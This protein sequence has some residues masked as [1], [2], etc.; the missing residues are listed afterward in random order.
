MT[1]KRFLSVFVALVM[2]LGLMPTA[3]IANAADTTNTTSKTIQLG[4][5]GLKSPTATT[6]EKGTYKEPNSYVYF[7]VNSENNSTPIKWRVLDADKANDGETNGMFLLSEYYLSLTRFDPT[8]P[9]DNTYQESVAKAWC[10]SFSGDQDNFSSLEYNNMLGI[11]KVDEP[12]TLYS[13]TWGA[14]T[15]TQYDKLFLLSVQELADYVGNYNE[16]PGLIAT[17]TAGF[18]QT[19]WLRSPYVYGNWKQ[20]AASVSYTGE[21]DNKHVEDNAGARPALNLNLDNVL[22]TSAAEDGKSASGMDSDLTAVNDYTGNEWKLT[23]KDTT[24]NFSITEN[25][26]TVETG[27]TITLNYSGASVGTNEYISA[28]IEDSNSNVSYYGR[29]LKPDANGGSMDITIPSGLVGGTCTLHLFSEQYNGGYKTDYASSFD[30]VSLTVVHNHA[31]SNEWSSDDTAHWHDCTADGCPITDNSEK[32]GY[33]IH[34]GGT[35]TCTAKAICADCG[36]EYGNLASHKLTH[37][38]AKAA[39]ATKTGNIEYWHCSDCDKY[40]KDKDAQ[41]EITNGINGTKISKLNANDNAESSH[42]GDNSNFALWIALLFISCTTV[43]GTTVVSRKKKY[44]K[45]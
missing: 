20:L 12:S 6:N 28:I 14:S 33:A 44:N 43:I 2:V 34:S 41:T 19:Y 40:F 38:A 15:L 36:K 16:A 5:S 39:T 18:A 13:L 45:N 10:A 24:R 37:I 22:F 27:D 32:D 29:V 21:V 8:D 1:K 30:D 11:L 3:N 9:Y 23:L 35:A 25:E 17:N 4:T 42:T 7:G 31:W 26:A